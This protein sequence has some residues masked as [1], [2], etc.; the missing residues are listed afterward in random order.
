MLKKSKDLKKLY[1][2]NIINEGK[3]YQIVRY[4]EPKKACNKRMINIV[5]ENLRPQEDEKILDIGCG[6]GTF[7]FHSSKV[8]AVVYGVDYS[9]ESVKM[10]K[11]LV[12]RYN[13][14]TKA[15]FVV[16]DATKIPFSDYN[17]DKI[18]TADFIEHISC[19][20]KEQLLKEIYSLLKP[21]GIGVIFSPNAIREK[22]SNFYWKLKNKILGDI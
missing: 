11:D 6:V 7:A 9:F 13:T 10:A 22:I 19:D 18:I 8:G 1:D 2:D 17:F 3:Q 4:Y 14:P 5:L 21:G 20:E 16:A 12:D 15:K